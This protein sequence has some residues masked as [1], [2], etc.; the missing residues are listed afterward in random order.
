M[1]PNGFFPEGVRTAFA[2]EADDP[3]PLTVDESSAISGA[4][5]SRQREFA[6]GRWCAKQALAEL[7]FFDLSI[8]V[9]SDRSPKWPE[10]I[11]GS[12][13]HCSGF[14]GAAVATSVRLEALGFDA[15][16]AE[17]LDADVLRSICT[18][19]EITWVETQSAPPAADWPKLIFS[20]KEAVYKC[21]SASTDGGLDFV[22]VTLDIEPEM[23]AFRARATDPDSPLRETLDRIHGRLA[24]DETLVYACAVIEATPTTESSG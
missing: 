10:G 8:P 19:A 6:L 5:E 16:P 14:V 11:V 3:P 1:L 24:Y 21:I 12:I 15:E 13:T 17:P 18:D 7:G 23:F 20:A 9:R 2:T 4:V 22:D